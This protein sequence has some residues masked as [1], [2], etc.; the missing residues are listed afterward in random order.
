MIGNDWRLKIGKKRI[1][2]ELGWRIELH[3]EYM[4][5]ADKACE[6]AN[7]CNWNFWGGGVDNYAVTLSQSGPDGKSISVK[8]IASGN[9]HYYACFKKVLNPNNLEIGDYD[10]YIGETSE[11]ALKYIRSYLIENRSINDFDDE[12]V[13]FMGGAYDRYP[14]AMK[15]AK[16][17][18]EEE[19]SKVAV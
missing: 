19:D 7:V 3:T 5:F 9:Y 12:C 8:M 16:E 2:G 1:K 13:C 6:I 15:W 4:K 10:T 17:I 11:D 18:M 14:L